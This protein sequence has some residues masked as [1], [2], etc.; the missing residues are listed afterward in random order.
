MQIHFDIHPDTIA[1][2]FS[3]AIEGGDP[4]TTAARGGW[5]AGIFWKSYRHKQPDQGVTP[6]YEVAKTWEGHFL[7]EIVEVDDERTGHKT[8]HKISEA[9]VRLGLETMARE[10]P[11][12]FGSVLSG[13]IDAACADV[14]LQCM[15]FGREKYA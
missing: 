15:L 11:S 8:R 12:R 10:Y 9:G 13:D 7:I 2:L 4:V 3:A 14:F 1:A 6:W 5:C